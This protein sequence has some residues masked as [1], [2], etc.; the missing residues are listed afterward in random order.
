MQAELEDLQVINIALYLST[1]LSHFAA[2]VKPLQLMM[3]K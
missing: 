2:E 1:R 3:L